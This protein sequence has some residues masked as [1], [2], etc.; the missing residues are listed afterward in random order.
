M[1]SQSVR[2]S[3]CALRLELDTAHATANHEAVV[4][5]AAARLAYRRAARVPECDMRYFYTSCT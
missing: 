3:I 5:G 2:E 1:P 4:V